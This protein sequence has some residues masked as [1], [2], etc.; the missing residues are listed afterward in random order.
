MGA[1]DMAMSDIE[2]AWKQAYEAGDV[3]A[4][5]AL[6]TDDAIYMAPYMGALRGRAAIEARFGE[7]AAMISSRQI[8]IN[9]TA[10]GGSGDLSYGVGTYAVQVQMAAVERSM[11][12]NGKYVTVA[13]RGADGSWKIHVHIWNTNMSEAEVVRMLSGMATM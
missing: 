12:D 3:V 5:A 13:K 11:T 8:T 10:Y 6:Y 4:L 7:Q 2:T 9:R 1:L